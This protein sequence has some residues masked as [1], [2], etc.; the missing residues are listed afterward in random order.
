MSGPKMDETGKYRVVSIRAL[1]SM[2]FS[3]IGA[4]VGIAT[5]HTLFVVP[6]ILAQ[7]HKEQELDMKEHLR[8]THA[9]EQASLLRRMDRLATKEGVDSLTRRLDRI[10]A[11]LDKMDGR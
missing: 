7:A 11:R 8:T 6:A 9:D 2:V 10:E 3:T 1:W 4:M 5:L